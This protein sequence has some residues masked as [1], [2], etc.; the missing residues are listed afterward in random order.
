VS[1]APTDCKPEAGVFAPVIDRNRCEGKAECERVC[2]Y[3]VFTIGRLSREE[4]RALTFLGRLKGLGH[5]YR[6]AFATRADACHACARCV[7]AC[8]ERAITLVRVVRRG[9][10]PT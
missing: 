5:G 2:P 7:A 6:Q 1:D 9:V 3:H 10:R 4:R 8:P